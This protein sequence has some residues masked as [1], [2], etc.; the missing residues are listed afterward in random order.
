MVITALAS[1]LGVDTNP[2]FERHRT[3]IAVAGLTLISVG[4]IANSRPGRRC[5]ALWPLLSAGLGQPV[6]AIPLMLGLL[7]VGGFYLLYQ[8][9]FSLHDTAWGYSHFFGADNVSFIWRQDGGWNSWEAN[10][11]PL[12]LLVTSL[13]YDGAGVF[14]N[15]VFHGSLGLNLRTIFPGAILGAVNVWLSFKIFVRNY[16]SQG[17][18]LLFTALYGLS[19][20]TWIFSSFP[21]TYAL[22][23]LVTNL[24]LL[25]LVRPMNVSKPS[26]IIAG[27]NALAA[28]AAPQQVILAVLPCLAHLTSGKWSMV[29]FRNVLLYTL[30]LMVLLVIPYIIFLSLIPSSERV[31]SGTVAYMSAGN[32]VSPVWYAVVPLNFLVF[33]VIGPN[34]SPELYSD[35]S[36]AALAHVSITWLL[37]VGLYALIC[38]RGLWG[39]RG[40]MATLSK[41]VPNILIFLALYLMTFIFFNPGESFLYP[42]PIL[43]IWL[44]LIH[45]GFVHGTSRK[46]QIALALLVLGVAV[47]NFGLILS[48]NDL[49]NY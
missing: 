11:H 36:L 39:L 20:A 26:P 35:P 16:P 40:S 37:I 7:L 46:W 42:F 19:A 21:S 2:G 48:L 9:S 27:A 33:A 38:A 34:I 28:F 32:L 13:I 44:L 14:I 10:R 12:F 3:L 15:M 30:F 18:A 8:L 4:I 23:A 1:I 17:T 43:L 5:I 47:N 41:M 24:F 49:I 6:R 25:T 29:A 31:I 45:T 22:T